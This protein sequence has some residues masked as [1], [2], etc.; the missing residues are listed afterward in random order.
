MEKVFRCPNV[1]A[2]CHPLITALGKFFSET[3]KQMTAWV[4]AQFLDT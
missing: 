4:S 1:L 2:R 3:F